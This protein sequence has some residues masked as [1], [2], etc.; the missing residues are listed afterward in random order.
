M[1]TNLTLDPV[2]ILGYERIDGTLRVAKS[3]IKAGVKKIYLSL[4]GPRSEAVKAT[5]ESIRA[6]FEVICK[7][8]NVSYKILTRKENLGLKLAVI[9]GINWFF[10]HETAGVIL[11]DDLL[12]SSQ[13]F[14]F[15]SLSKHKFDSSEKILLVSGN[16]FESD[17][18]TNSPLLSRYPLIWGWFTSSEKWETI[19]LL[20]S[21]RN[22][23]RK[24][25]LR[26]KV[27]WFW[28][29]GAM[30][31]RAGLNNS[32]A[33]PFAEG[34]RKYGFIGIVPSCNLVSNV[35]VD[36]FA[37]HTTEI[38]LENNFPIDEKAADC[39][40]SNYP[41]W[42]FPLQDP[43]LLEKQIYRIHNKHYLLILKIMQMKFS[44][45]VEKSFHGNDKFS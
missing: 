10:E 15:V 14:D 42:E 44:K 12:V 1:N 22:L 3:A 33:I 37:S 23:G 41:K 31:S 26:K 2:L 38:E 29:Y 21:G 16:Q 35:G 9:D 4:D 19:K 11:E 13:F 45:F 25:R 18:D 17:F 6:E 5:Q 36:E 28:R 40:L 7:K 34:F 39:L 32:W 43:R 8:S 24:I 27:E 30:R 20:I